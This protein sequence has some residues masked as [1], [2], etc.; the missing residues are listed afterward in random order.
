MRDL[1]LRLPR[2][3]VLAQPLIDDLAPRVVLGPGDEFDLGDKLGPDPM[4]AA[5][6]QRRAEA[7]AARG[8][9]SSGIE[10]MASGCSRRHSRSSSAVSMPV[11]TRPA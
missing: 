7:G 4:H 6:H 11:A 10:H 8:G 2:R 9:A 5:Q 1:L 3:V